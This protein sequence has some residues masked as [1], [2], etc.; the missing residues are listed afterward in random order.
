MPDRNDRYVFIHIPKTAGMSLRVLLGEIFGPEA[1][2]PARPVRHIGVDEAR[3]LEAYPVIAEHISW[4]DVATCFPGR[5]VF[6]F[7]RDPVDRCLSLYGYLLQLTHLPLLPLDRIRGLNNAE[8]ATS[9]ARQLDP[10]DFFRRDHPHLRQNLENRMVWQLGYRAAVEHRHEVPPREALAMARRNL[11]TLLFTGF[12]ENLDNDTGRLRGLLTGEPRTGYVSPKVNQT[13][14]P[15]RR[16]DVGSSTLRAIERLTELDRR[17]YD[18]AL[19]LVY[20]DRARSL[21]SS[22][23]SVLFRNRYARLLL[24]TEKN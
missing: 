11:N 22:W 15:L 2:S 12:Y 3:Q 18:S 21:W 19:K 5:K 23:T 4:S 16:G 1:V 17:L 6:T 13:V 10:E 14:A 8:E 9:L 20:A 24:G 7:L